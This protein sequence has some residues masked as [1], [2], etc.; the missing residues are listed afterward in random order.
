MEP[1]ALLSFA[2]LHGRSIQIQNLGDTCRQKNR[3]L[4]TYVDPQ[5]NKEDSVGGYSVMDAIS[6]ALS[7]SQAELRARI[8]HANRALF[9][10]D[11]E[12]V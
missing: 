2:N 5:T 6:K 4:F 1:L 10:D 8:L 11:I 9:V 12:R 3:V 7:R